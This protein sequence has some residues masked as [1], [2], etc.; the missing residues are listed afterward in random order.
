MFF[1]PPARFPFLKACFYIRLMGL[2]GWLLR[3][4]L[5]AS[6]VFCWA[7]IGAQTPNDAPTSWQSIRKNGRGEITVYW[8]ESKP[9]IYRNATEQLEGVEYDLME[10][11]RK[12]LKDRYDVDLKMNWKEAN[13]FHNTYL[14]VQQD[15]HHSFFWCIRI[16]HH[17][18][19]RNRSTVR[20]PLH[21]RH[22][23]ADIEPECALHPECFRLQ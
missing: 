18:P 15:P 23:G 9:F 5:T 14:T 4:V 12:F 2:I 1:Q 7:T 22:L 8:F 11:F 6:M 19:T 20:P 17:Q 21:G 13:D 16:L 10:G 3:A